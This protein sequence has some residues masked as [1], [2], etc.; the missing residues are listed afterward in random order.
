MENQNYFESDYARIY[1]E[2]VLILQKKAMEFSDLHL[3][4]VGYLISCECIFN[5]IYYGGGIWSMGVTYSPKE[6][7][8]DTLHFNYPYAGG[9][10]SFEYLSKIMDD[11]ISGKDVLQVWLE[12]EKEESRIHDIKRSNSFKP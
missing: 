1:K 9:Y 2:Q 10:L 6:G 4:E 12:K 7:V 5:H 8:S 3:A 11:L